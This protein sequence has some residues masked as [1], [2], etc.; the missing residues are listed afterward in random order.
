LRSPIAHVVWFPADTADHE[1]GAPANVISVGSLASPLIVS[2]TW[3]RSLLPQQYK[4]PSAIPQMCSP[5]ASSADQLR[6]RSSRVAYGNWS[7]LEGD[8]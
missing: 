6:S 5:P 7:S 3:P 8:T 4:R 2:E 1:L